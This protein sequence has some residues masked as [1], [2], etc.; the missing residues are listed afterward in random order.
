MAA[1]FLYFHLLSAGYKD[2]RGTMAV[3]D[4]HF[5]TDGHEPE[6]AISGDN[7]SGKQ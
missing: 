3:A 6:V 4:Y 5:G 2:A 1:S 7:Y